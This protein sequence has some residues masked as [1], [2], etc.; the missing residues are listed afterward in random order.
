MVS[1]AYDSEADALYIQL[2][3]GEV[4]RTEDV[5]T[6]TLVDVDEA[7]VAL[8][9]EVLHP[10]R[11]WPLDEILR[12]YRIEGHTAAMLRAMHPNIGEGDA[13]VSFGSPCQGVSAAGRLQAVA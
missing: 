6:G 2:D 3:V 4:A 7:G 10:A 13:R 8:G 5:D 11:P 12:R 1:H 9:I